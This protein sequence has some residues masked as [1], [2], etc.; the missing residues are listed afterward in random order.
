MR[1]RITMVFLLLIYLIGKLPAQ[2]P[3]E[4]F[5]FAK[6]KFDNGDFVESRDY[7]DKAL[8]EDSLYVNAF[9]L[10]AETNYEL[11]NYY[12]SIND[13][14]SIFKIEN[15]TSSF[16]GNHYL[17]R[18]KSYL[19]LEDFSNASDDFEKCK[20]LSK[21]NAELHYYNARLGKATR[22]F[23]QAL[24]NLDTAIRINSDN[25]SYYAFRSEINIA[26][27]RPL[28]DS[29]GYYDV[30]D[31]IN[32][33]IALDPD[34][35]QYYLIRSN[36]LKSMGKVDDAVADY[37]KMIE[38]SPLN[39]KA[40]TERGVINLH[41]YEYQNAVMDFTKSILISPNDERNYRYRGLCY[42]NMD[43]YSHAYEDFTKSIDLLTVEYPKTKNKSALKKLLAETYLLRGHCLN[44]MGYNAQAC[45]DFLFAHNLGMRK[46][47]NYY[48]RYCGNY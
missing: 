46:G 42:N 17:T 12:N 44:L 34:N 48:R 45:K 2:D 13:I 36:F 29:R 32:L 22:S 10:R 26:Y 4:Y 28:R 30:L 18:G 37:N 11:G 20:A 43:D 33:A 38:L 19:S 31:D 7:L 25:P 3:R 47:L 23:I 15:I 8:A 16:S 21:N 9:Y 5:K 6:F 41:K 1:R 14:N 39:G 24:E 40:Y 27:L 35:Y